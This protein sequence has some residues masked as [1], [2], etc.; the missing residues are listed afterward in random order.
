MYIDSP[1][2]AKK[3]A[4]ALKRASAKLPG[5]EAWLAVPAPLLAPLK[6]TATIGAQDISQ[7]AE[8]AHTGEVSAAL[9]RHAGAS[10]SLVGHSERRAMGE[11][12]ESVRE[13]LVRA[14]E[15]A[16]APVLCIGERER[17][18]EGAHWSEL[19]AQLF[20]ALRSTQRSS[21]LIIAYEPVWAIGKHSD[22]AMKPAELE[23]TVIF[24]RKTLADILG[25]AE[26]LK[27]PVLYGGSVD[28]ENAPSL[29]AEGGVNGFLVGRASTKLDSFVAILNSCKK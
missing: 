14:A 16:L 19:E 3:F 4:Q 11:S 9:A 26:A 20:S 27:V 22:D 28:K 18:P 5:T 8:G 12:D 2:A 29:I 13:K 21:K 15:A 24:I 25:R 23:E 7:F 10:F 6:G 1:D 17:S